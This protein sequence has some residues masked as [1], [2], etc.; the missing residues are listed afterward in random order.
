MTDAIP[1][2]GFD[3]QGDARAYHHGI[4][5]H[6]RQ[7]GC[8]YFVTYRQADALPAGVICEIEYE[9]DQWLKHRGIELDDLAEAFRKLS[10]ADRRA[11][12]RLMASRLNDFLDAGH[13]TCALRRSD[14]AQIV[15]QS[16]YH[17]HGKRVLTGDSVVMPN[18][19]H[20]SMRPLPGFE[21]EGI[22]QAIKSFTATEI[23][24][25][26]GY[27]GRFWMKESYDH[28]VRD[29]DQLEAFQNYIMANPRKA[30]LGS[31]EF[32]LRTATWR[33]DE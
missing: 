14:I 11:Y 5:P 6:W 8:T 2:R 4:L 24:R 10:H 9:R 22:L 29:F 3:E 31:D 21:L 7:A 12:E 30:H 27:S 32:I 25:R 17:F 18:H 23:N 19:V 28:I 1:F 13:G 33:P 15:I 26:L 16:L 20:T